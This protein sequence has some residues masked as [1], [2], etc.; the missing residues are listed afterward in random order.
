M[1]K[2]PVKELSK[3]CTIKPPKS[4]ARELLSAKDEV[5]FVPMN[6]LETG[7]KTFSPECTKALA[8]VSSS[9][10][11]FADGDVLL[12]KITPCFENG[13]LGVARNLKNGIGFGSSEFV[14]YRPSEA[15]NADYLFYYF[16]QQIFRDEGE[17]TMGG[18]VGHK[19]IQ[20]GFFE[21]HNIPVPPLAEQE[22]LVAILDEACEG[23][24]TATAHT[25]RKL[26]NAQELFQ[27]TLESAF[28]GNDELGIKNEEWVETTLHEILKDQPRNG[29]SPPAANHSESGTPVLTLSSVTGFRFKKDKVKFTSAKTDPT[30]HYWVRNGDLL[31]SRSNTPELVG[32]VAVASGIECPTIYPDLIMKM[33]PAPE[34]ADTQFVYYQLRNPILREIITGRATGANPT[35]KKIN[36]NSVQTLPISLPPLPEQR[37][38]VKKLDALSAETRRLESGYRR[39]LTALTE[40]KQSLLAAAFSGNL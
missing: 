18:A 26:Q 35:M 10:T 7:L 33:M 31:I 9:Y 17:R 5:S 1:S 14:V 27:S 28:G 36:K 12:A 3:V 29:W 15:I 16:S 2:W 20:K 32:H 22:R 37:A 40:L 13:K 6:C 21:G 4:E 39:Q 25:E 19:R 34:K 8:E 23:I 24:A 11:Y 38:I 30:R